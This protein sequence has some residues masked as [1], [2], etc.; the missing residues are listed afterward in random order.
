M[1]IIIVMQ[2]G[3]SGIEVEHIA[4]RFLNSSKEGKEI[5]DQRFVK[6]DC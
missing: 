3:L 5:K 2:Y 1:L 6:Q 4:M